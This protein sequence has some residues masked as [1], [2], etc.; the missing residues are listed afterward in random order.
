MSCRLVPKLVTLNDLEHHNGR[1]LLVS[2]P[3]SLLRSLFTGNRHTHS[4]ATDLVSRHWSSRHEAA[5]AAADLP[6]NRQLWRKK[7]RFR[8]RTVF[9]KNL[10]FGIGF[11]YRNNTTSRLM[12]PFLQVSLVWQTDRPTDHATRSVTLGRIYVR[13]TAIRPNNGL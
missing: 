3:R 6:Q 4:I 9:A 12:Q 1:K 11:G 2:V 5:A 8:R 7:P 13:S 10:G